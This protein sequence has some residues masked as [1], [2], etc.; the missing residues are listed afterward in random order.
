MNYDFT[1]LIYIFIRS[2]SLCCFL[3]INYRNCGLLQKGLIA[4]ILTI[5]GWLYTSKIESTFSL[6]SMFLEIVFGALLALPY[7]LVIEITLLFGE[8]LNVSRGQQLAGVQDT[9]MLAN[10]SDI[11]L[12]L[13]NALIAVLLVMNVATSG[14]ELYLKLLSIFSVGQLTFNQFVTLSPQLTLE[15]TYFLS[16]TVCFFLMFSLLFIIIDW[17]CSITAKLFP[18]FHQMQEG[19]ILKS[20]VLF[21]VFKVLVNENGFLFSLLFL[22]KPFS[23]IEEAL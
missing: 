9:I 16:N 22:V 18:A 7:L 1:L 8:L 17:G 14:I 2:F 13:K 12:L 19:F 3:P 21:L 20:F 11:G 15:I 5:L 4:I 6:S 10:V 23:F